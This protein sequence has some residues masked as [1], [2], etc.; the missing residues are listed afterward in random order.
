M[1]PE[2]NESLTVIQW[3][4]T[5]AS[6]TGAAA[7]IGAQIVRNRAVKDN[8][9]AIIFGIGLV[10]VGVLSLITTLLSMA[11][12]AALVFGWIAP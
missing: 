2:I 4:V 6:I 1:T 3:I 12:G 9:K 7:L 8:R 10:A 5:T 11:L